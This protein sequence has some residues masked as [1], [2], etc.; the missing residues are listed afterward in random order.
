[1]AARSSGLSG[2][3]ARGG[4][5]ILGLRRRFLAGEG[6]ADGV[7]AAPIRRSWERCAALGLDM[8]RLPAIEPLSG[9]ALR[10]SRERNERLRRAARAELLALHHDA[11]AS[12]GIVILTDA[13]GLVLDTAGSPDFAEKAARVAL[14]PGVAWREAAT[15]TNA[16][17]TA[18]AERREISVV[19]AE[20]FFEMHRVL[21]CTAMP[22]LDARGETV[23]VLDLSNPAA[24]RE[25][26]AA[27]LVR[28]AVEAIEHRLFDASAADWEVVRF[29][30]DPEQIGS[31]RE[32]LLAF[33]GDRLVGANRSGLALIER[34]W[35]AVGHLGWS[36]VF[37]TTRRRS[38]DDGQLR[39]TAG[40]MLVGRAEAP[41]RSPMRGE[42]VPSILR[43]AEAE[44]TKV[45]PAAS[46]PPAGSGPRAAAPDPIWDDTRRSALKRAVR[47][48]D[49]DVP[50]LIQGET[51]VGKEVFARALHDASRLASKPFVAINCAALPEG[52]I[53]AEL[54]G[55]EE[56]AFTGA[57]K[58]G[59]KGL[60]RAAD[61][62]VLFLDEIGDMPAGLQARLLR[63]LQ[64]RE[65][66]P[67]GAARPVPVAFSL[68]CATHRGLADL[69]EAR[70]FRQDLYFRI[71]P[72][73]V[74]LEPLRRHP[75]RGALVDEIWARIGGPAAK[76]TLGAEL[77]RHL[78][79]YDWPGNWRQLVGTLRTLLVLAEP[80]ETLDTSVLPPDLRRGPAL[81][82]ASFGPAPAAAGDLD[83]IT[84]AA[85]RAALADCGGN[86][87]R[88][89]TRLGVHRSTLY[90][91]L[92]MRPV[93]SA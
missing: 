4:G 92:T 21:T 85:M 1:M 13:E 33:A 29:H 89:A 36:D 15:G 45:A 61:G 30:V 57:R 60:M 53:E 23:G 31:V 44:P 34:D 67:L 81:G 82:D 9:G 2:A 28:R 25:T 69:V 59:S 75:D 93:G 79:A 84:V 39:T 77:R 65:V 11:R 80:G 20:H 37:A 16:I 62:G 50:V 90:R 47:L 87:S 76:V 40:R 42:A 78:A 64:E 43:S 72:Y 49:A 51:G 8:A 6:L 5:E 19:G 26:H 17:G 55:Y 71:A 58:A 68:I 86:V 18:I 70:A 22:I 24:V 14:R 46:E 63:A 88:A 3:A 12:G 66:T 48:V 73:T 52:L 83:A 41:R 74:E 27:G 38:G 7:V 35:E 54:F 91:R 56:G 32:G 10:E